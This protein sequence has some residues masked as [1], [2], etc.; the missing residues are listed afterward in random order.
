MLLALD[1]ATSTGYAYGAPGSKPTVGHFVLPPTGDNLG[2]ALALYIRWLNTLIEQRLITKVVFEAPILPK[3]PNFKMVRKLMSLAGATEYVA[4][5]NKCDP[6][7]INS[8]QWRSPFLGRSFYPRPANRRTLNAACV[9]AA[10]AYGYMAPDNNNEDDASAAG[11]WHVMS[12]ARGL[13]V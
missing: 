2:R 6:T 13:L 12:S 7:E 10:K 9:T 5:V 11:I 1:V 4:H 8:S 3:K